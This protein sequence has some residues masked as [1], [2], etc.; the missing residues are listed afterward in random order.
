MEEKDL[1]IYEDDE[2]VKYILENV[3]D[4]YK[5]KITCEK[6]EY[7]LELVYQYYEKEGLIQ[8]DA[9]EE[10]DIDEADM[11]EFICEAADTDKIEIPDDEVD[12][13]LNG[14][15]E[16]GKSIGVYEEDSETGK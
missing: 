16:Y 2:A 9:A 10:A 15:F 7:V 14:E 12:V 1:L 4:A 5:G 3:P 6:V 13:I 11:F 8:E